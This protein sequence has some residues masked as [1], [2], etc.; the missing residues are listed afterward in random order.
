VLLR[1]LSACSANESSSSNVACAGWRRAICTGLQGHRGQSTLRLMTASG[2]LLRYLGL[3]LA[4]V[5]S[6]VGFEGTSTAAAVDSAYVPVREPVLGFAL[7]RSQAD[8][9]YRLVELDPTADGPP[10]WKTIVEG[11]LDTCEA[12]LVEVLEDKYGRGRLNLPV[13]TLGGK[14]FWADEFVYAGWR[15]QH[16]VYTDHYRL[17]D[18]EDERRAW[19]SYE[20]CRTVFEAQRV[21]GKIQ[22]RSDDLVVLL[23]GLFRSKASLRKLQTALEAEGY[24]VATVSYPSTRASIRDHAD[25]LERVL[26][27]LE[28]TRRISFV[29]HSL[30][31]IVAREVLAR[32]SD[33]K[34]RIEIGRLVMLGTPNQGSVV[35]ELLRDWLPYQIVA[36]KSGQE[37]TL[38]SVAGVPPPACSFGIIAGGTGDDR[39]LNPLLPGDNDGT[40]LVADTRLEGADDFLLVR[41]A[42]S[43]LMS[44]PEV[45]KAT[46]RFLKEGRFTKAIELDAE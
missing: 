9:G 44:D 26:N 25:Q 19:G 8:D 17:L 18:P 24:E 38:G 7:E 3:L 37:L 35:A 21:Q 10:V 2:K 46:I 32:D 36:G 45:I 4:F 11:P 6:A 34:K 28:G 15:I 40:V 5:G 30:G 13:G 22:P 29:T 1:R 16:N 39:G 43:W 23:H 42:H 41:R 27:A 20:A 33:W 12:R 14:Q 31:G